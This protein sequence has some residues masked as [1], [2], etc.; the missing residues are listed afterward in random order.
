MRL[1]T[2]RLVLLLALLSGAL[3]ASCRHSVWSGRELQQISNATR[4]GTVAYVANMSDPAAAGITQHTVT[5]RQALEN[6]KVT[7]IILLTNYTAGASWHRQ[8]GST[9]H[10]IRKE[11]IKEHVWQRLHLASA[12]GHQQ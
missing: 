6:P 8:S 4:T 3:E 1:A 12:H 2:A 9:C 11:G 7:T 5:L 10:C